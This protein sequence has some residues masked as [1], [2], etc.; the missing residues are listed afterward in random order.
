MIERDDETPTSDNEASSNTSS[1]GPG[2]DVDGIESVAP[3]SVE[4][5]AIEPEVVELHSVPA[6]PSEVERL[7]AQ[8][9]EQSARLR[10]VSKAYTDLQ[11]E[12]DAFRKRQQVLAEAKAER[13]AGEVIERFFEPV[14]NLK[15]ALEAD[16]TAEDLRGGVRLVLQQFARQM[17]DL[18]LSE[19]PGEGAPFDPK[20]H[21]ALAVMPVTDPAQDGTIITVHST[22]WMVNERVIQPAKVVIGKY[23]EPGEA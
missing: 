9:T 19:V 10:T 14:Q 4:P 7:Q 5:E 23:T 15:R 1:N 11:K 18:G 20:V 12:M 8:L 17:T 13:K 22:G 3:E 2:P 16:G 6:D 21:D